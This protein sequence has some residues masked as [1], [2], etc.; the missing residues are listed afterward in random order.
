MD[1]E[2]RDFTIYLTSEIIILTLF[3]EGRI[4]TVVESPAEDKKE[5]LGRKLKN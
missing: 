2:H 3:K 5:E 4:M 1:V